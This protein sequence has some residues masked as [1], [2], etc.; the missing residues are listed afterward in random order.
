[1]LCA[2]GSTELKKTMIRATGTATIIDGMKQTGVKRLI[3]VS[4]M[5]VSA[6]WDFLSPVNKLFLASLLRSALA[7]HG[8]QEAAVMSSGL[9]WMDDRSAKRAGGHAWDGCLRRW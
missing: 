4:A 1:M 7:D 8:A 9:D 5:G 2:L 3:V 6:S